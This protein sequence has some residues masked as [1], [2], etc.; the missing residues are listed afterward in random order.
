M[1][2][3]VRCICIVLA[4]SFMLAIP[5]SANSDDNQRASMFFS[6]YSV[7]IAENGGTYF[8][9]CY[10]VTGKNTMQEIGA[11]WM[12]IQESDDGVVWTTVRTVTTEF[13]PQMIC[14]NTIGHSWWFGYSATSGKCYR[15]EVNLW[16]KNSLGTG[17]RTVYSDPVWF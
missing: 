8:Q 17:E 11:T 15:L 7:Y 2:R 10:S 3:I 16:A 1:R 6:V 12:E 9:A 13:Y 4:L 14:Y 5:V